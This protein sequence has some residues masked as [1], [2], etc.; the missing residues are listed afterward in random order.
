MAFG[1]LVA[2]LDIL[3]SP[4][5]LWYRSHIAM[6]M[7]T[8]ITIHKMVVELRRDFYESGL[9]SCKFSEGEDRLFAAGTM[10]T[11]QSRPASELRMGK[12]C[13]MECG[14]QF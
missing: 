14:P 1:V 13:Q 4:E 9:F 11:W 5:K 8:C 7:E 10:F 2:R 3:K 6:V 12:Y